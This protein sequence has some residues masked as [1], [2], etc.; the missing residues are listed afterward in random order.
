MR[1]TDSL[2]LLSVKAMTELPPILDD[3]ASL[4]EVLE[5]LPQGILIFLDLKLIF[6]NS[7]EAKMLG[8]EVSEL[9]GISFE[10]TLKMIHPDDQHII[11]EAA[12]AMQ[13]NTNATRH[14]RIRLVTRDGR[15]TPID[16]YGH[17]I[18]LP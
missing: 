13:Q 17:H 3:I 14:D 7:A 12:E 4:Q 6:T 10:E 5:Q 18:Y 16:N 11:L 8:Y 15:I 9:I 1:C 2:Q